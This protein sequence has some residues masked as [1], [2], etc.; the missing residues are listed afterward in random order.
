MSEG[1]KE[2][3]K[4]TGKGK[5]DKLTERR[6]RSTEGKKGYIEGRE[7]SGTWGRGRFH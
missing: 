7:S 2:N 5:K 1:K 3:S 6:V 4:G